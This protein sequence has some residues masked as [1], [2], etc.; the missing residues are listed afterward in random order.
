MP[1]VLLNASVANPAARGRVK[2]C[3]VK[4]NGLRCENRSPYDRR[5]QKWIQRLVSG[6]NRCAPVEQVVDPDFHHLDIAVVGGEPIAGKERGG[7]RNDEGPVAQTE[8]I[9]FQPHHPIVRERIFVASA[10]QPA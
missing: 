9:V 4:Y 3:A 10:Y 7:G 2:V 5:S 8:I 1:R 6:G